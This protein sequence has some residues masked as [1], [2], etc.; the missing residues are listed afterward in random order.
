MK[1]QESFHGIDRL[2]SYLPLLFGLL[3]SCLILLGFFD[4]LPLCDDA[5]YYFEI[6]RNATLGEG[7]SFDSVH[8]TNGFHPLWALCLLP[9]Y[10]ILGETPWP[11]IRFAMLVSAWLLSC[12]A[13][14]TRTILHRQGETRAGFFAVLFWLWNPFTVVMGLQGVEGPLNVCCLAWSFLYLQRITTSLSPWNLACLGFTLGLSYLARTENMLWILCV[15]G[16]LFHQKWKEGGRSIIHAI[17]VLSLPLLFIVTPWLY[18]N[19]TTFGTLEQTSGTAKRLFHLYGTLPSL[20]PERTEWKDILLL[21]VGLARNQAHI[22]LFLCR[23]VVG[24]EFQPMRKGYAI[25]GALLTYILLLL[26]LPNHSRSE[27]RTKSNARLSV[28]SVLGVFSL[29]HLAVYGWFLRNYYSWYVPPILWSFSLWQGIR[30]SRCHFRSRTR[31][32]MMGTT[33]LSILIGSWLFCAQVFL[34]P[35]SP[36]WHEK[37]FRSQFASRM[38][39]LEKGTRAGLWNAGAVGYFS[40]FYFPNLTVV[41]LDGVVNN[42]VTRAERRGAYEAFLLEEVDVLLEP[43]SFL[44]SIMGEDRSRQFFQEHIEYD[45]KRHLWW[46]RSR[47][48]FGD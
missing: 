7:W 10:R 18:W 9:C 23:Y 8:P 14:L 38:S 39:G 5:F 20:S 2:A 22:L 48:G 24:E 13:W 33:G 37:A 46:I 30:L 1:T 40:S 11:A 35:H 12:A 47:L 28:L 4:G 34:W 44:V 31:A 25:L 21:P 6:C 15:L 43:P 27:S 3:L 41:N 29:L 26:F 17:P 16:W 45:E 36:F 42:R 32:W 19:M